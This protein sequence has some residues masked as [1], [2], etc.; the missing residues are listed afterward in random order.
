M[1]TYNTCVCIRVTAHLR[2]LIDIV[3]W[4]RSKIIVNIKHSAYTLV[5][6]QSIMVKNLEKN[7]QDIGMKP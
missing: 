6:Y 3:P 4:C 2:K 7:M 5:K 1:H